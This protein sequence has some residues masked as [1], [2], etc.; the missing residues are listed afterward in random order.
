MTTIIQQYLIKS[1]EL[2]GT[3]IEP[4]FAFITVKYPHRKTKDLYNPP[5][6]DDKK[7]LTH[8][9]HCNQPNCPNDI[10]Y[11][12]LSALLEHLKLHA[13]KSLKKVESLR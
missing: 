4:M 5:Y 6:T 3:I 1:G 7:K 9:W 10:F 11:G 8:P 13:G 2:E 12:D